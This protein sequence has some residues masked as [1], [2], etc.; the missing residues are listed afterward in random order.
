MKKKNPI[1]IPFLHYFFHYMKFQNKFIITHLLLVLVPTLVLIFFISNQLSQVI[2]ANTLESEQAL[3]TQTSDTLASTIDKLCLTVDNILTQT[4]LDED[5]MKSDY[6]TSSLF[7]SGSDY[8]QIFQNISSMV[9]GQLITSIRIY[10]PS[11]VMVPRSI[12][13]DTDI[14]Q[15]LSQVKASYWHGI[16]Q[17]KPKETQLFCPDFYLTKREITTLGGNAYIRK[18][19][20]ITSADGEHA[21][22]VIY[23]ST[24]YMQNILCNNIT[25]TGSVYYIINSRNNLVSSSDPRLAGTYF[26]RY[27][28]IPDS[29]GSSSHF[30]TYTILG[31]SLYMGYHD[32]PGTDWRLVAVIP[33]NSIMLQ[34]K[35]ILS[36]SIYLYLLFVMLA[37][38]TALM[39]SS[40]MAKRI[41]KVVDTMNDA[42]D[43]TLVKMKQETDK[44]EIGQLA[45]N[46]NLMVDRINN[47]V[48]E[49]TETAEKLKV[50]EVKA[51]QAQINPHFLYNMLDM[52]NWLSQCGKQKE[53][54]IAVQTL[55]KFYKLTLS[56]KNIFTTIKEELHHVEL[57]V[58]L[59]NMRYEDS[60]QFIIDVPNEILDLQIP[61]LVLQPIVENSIQ[62]GIFE[63]E[64][65]SGEIVIM[66]W[67]DASD[68]VFVISDN[69]MGIPP[70]KLPTILNGSGRS[71]GK[72]S[73]IAIYNTHQRLQL[74]YGEKYGLHYDSTYGVGTEVRVNIPAVPFEE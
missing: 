62:H 31:E 72:G 36:N 18:L 16:F 27:E 58:Q 41:S 17:G 13:Q 69:G 71:S 49:Q 67:M 33:A 34:S 30:T 66:A 55:S 46:Y 23:F 24:D 64:T 47:L 52:I 39:L 21:Y 61:K 6:F 35:Q 38:V 73:N 74:I 40:S 63:K 28:S 45:Y 57:Y 10:Y 3:V 42:R 9:D 68:V 19:P 56:Q 22:I 25:G 5:N 11:S 65:K 48:A 7:T 1:H 2:E 14:L 29:L 37:F 50:S 8:S 54:S 59:Q 20:Y 51:L 4:E 44:D 15:P 43:T 60:I 70:E 26:M 12:L 32:V 53:V